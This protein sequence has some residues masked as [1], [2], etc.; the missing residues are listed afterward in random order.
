MKKKNKPL[1]IFLFSAIL[2]PLIPY[3]FNVENPYFKVMIFAI[4]GA[5]LLYSVYLKE[6]M[7]KP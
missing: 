5:G 2:L 3:F 1:F 4:A 6:V 7:K